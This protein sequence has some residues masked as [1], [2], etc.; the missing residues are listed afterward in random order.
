MQIGALLDTETESRYAKS[1]TPLQAEP[2]LCVQ[3][4]AAILRVPVSWVY[5]RTRQRGTD[6][7]P[8]LKVGKYVRFR[9]SE[10][11]KYLERLR[12]G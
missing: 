5:E 12:R 8:H 4:I 10:V 6:Q 2:L 3:D 7:L 1:S 9:L 11:E